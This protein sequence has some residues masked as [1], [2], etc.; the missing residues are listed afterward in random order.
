MAP[1]D[2]NQPDEGR[3]NAAVAAAAAA[4]AAAGPRVN[5]IDDIDEEWLEEEIPEEIPEWVKVDNIEEFKRLCEVHCGN[6]EVKIWEMTDI[7]RIWKN[8]AASLRSRERRVQQQQQH[9]VQ[10]RAA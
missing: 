2:E 3:L 5:Q 6:D 8:R 7:R 4:V 10:L 1:R 9:Q